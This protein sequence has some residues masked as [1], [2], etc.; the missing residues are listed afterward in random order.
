MV[1]KKVG[2]FLTTI[3]VNGKEK[4]STNQS[5]DRVFD[6]T[7]N[8]DVVV[9]VNGNQK[10][11]DS[12]NSNKTYNLSVNA[13][14]TGTNEVYN[15]SPEYYH[16]ND[17]NDTYTMTY[18]PNGFAYVKVKARNT[19]NYGDSTGELFIDNNKITTLYVSESAGTTKY[20]NY[21][22]NINEVKYTLTNNSSYSTTYGFLKVYEPILSIS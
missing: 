19:A 5:D 8:L 6:I 2:E 14:I 10:V 18:N 13:E 11:S 12:I 17:N 7:E 16:L 4:I 20:Y 15:H 3:N 21:F 22:G 9:N 1:L